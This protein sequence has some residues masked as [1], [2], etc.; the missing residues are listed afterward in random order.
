M[1]FFNIEKGLELP[2]V[3][4]IMHDALDE[5]YARRQEEFEKSN[6]LQHIYKMV[7]LNQFQKS[8]GSST[9]FKQAFEQTVDYASYPGFSTGD[10]FRTTISYKPFNGKVT[11]T[12]QLLME[13]DKSAISETLADYQFAWHRQ[14][15]EYGVFALTSFF[16]S[17]VFDKVSKSYLKIESAD[18]VD[19][20]TMSAVKNPVFTNAH[21]IVR[22]EGMSD[23]EFNGMKQ[24]N[25]FYINVKLDG[26][27]VAPYQKVANGLYQIKV[28]MNKYLDDNGQRA[29]LRGRK[30]LV[31]TEDAHLNQAI[32]VI[33]AAENWSNAI[34]KLDLNPVKGDFDT[35]VTSYLDGNMNQPIPQFAVN[36]TYGHAFGMLMLD[37]EYNSRNKGPM[38]VERLKFTM[39]A[40]KTK[41]PEGLAYYGKQA[42]DFFCPSWRGIA[43]IMIGNPTDFYDAGDATTAWANPATFTEINPVLNLAAMHTIETTI[44]E[45]LYDITMSV[46][47]NGT[48]VAA[49]AEAKPGETVALTITPASGYVVDTITVGVLPLATSATSFVM[50]AT[51]VTVAVTFKT[52]A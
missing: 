10:G 42:F 8:F 23:T 40:D 46:G 29:G 49:K 22:R 19:G 4:N 13:A 48:A 12:W 11:F 14:V 3:F 52:S 50:P 34:G 2:Q 15:V 20:D 5:L 36:Q 37:P 41:D 28:R 21:T 33:L 6:P 31:M 27:E 7:Q 47:T 39:S 51:D 24:S 1:R 30:K 17:K 9:G 18:T 43:Y 26:S 35:Y 32:N 38:M 25:K 44:P 16:G 45:T